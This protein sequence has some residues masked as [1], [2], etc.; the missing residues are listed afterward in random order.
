MFTPSGFGSRP[1][2]WQRIG[3]PRAVSMIK[4][5]VT[6]ADRDPKTNTVVRASGLIAFDGGEVST[7]AIGYTVGAV[8]VDLQLVGTSGV[9]G[10]DDFVMDWANSFVFKN[11]DIEIDV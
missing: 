6:T 3:T 9:I 5:V 8:L 7:L 11:S 1:F 10:M 4:K 2:K